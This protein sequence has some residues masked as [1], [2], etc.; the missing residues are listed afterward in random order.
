MER[1][2]QILYTETMKFRFRVFI[3][4]LFLTLFF[5]CSSNEN[6]KID[7]GSGWQ[8][9][10][11][12]PDRDDCNFQL[13][14]DASLNHLE[15]LLTESSKQKSFISKLFS[16]NSSQPKTIWLKKDFIIPVELQREDI[17]IYLGHIADS[18]KTYLNHY[19]IGNTLN[20][21]DTCF[22]YFNVPRFYEIPEELL[23]PGVNTIVIEITIGRHGFLKGNGFISFYKD[24]RIAFVRDKFFSELLYFAFAVILFFVS[25]IFISE[26]RKFYNK[27]ELILFCIISFLTSIDLSYF[28]I[29]EMPFI[30]LDKID[31]TIFAVIF[32]IL[33]PI[34]IAIIFVLFLRFLYQKEKEYFYKI[35]YC[36]IIVPFFI[37]LDVFLQFGM[38]FTFIP[39]LSYYSFPLCLILIFFVL[40]S[41]KL[42][43]LKPLKSTEDLKFSRIVPKIIDTENFQVAYFFK[44]AR[45]AKELMYD[46]FTEEN[47]LTGLTIFETAKND[48]SGTNLIM[49]AKQFVGKTFSDNKKLSLTKVMEKINQK[50]TEQNSSTNFLNGTLLRFSENRVE[51]V[52]SSHTVPFYRVSKTGVSV[53]VKLKDSESPVS[54]IGFS[55]LPGDAVILYSRTFENSM[56]PEQEPFSAQRIQQ[57]F[58]QSGSGTSL[59]RLEYILNMFHNYT[60][61]VLS[62]RDLAVLIVQK[63]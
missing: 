54:G 24:A 6:V 37:I 30:S 40:F 48:S 57:A 12:S 22:S 60:N 7:L 16:G 52:N 58:R 32:N 28:F 39:V 43:E 18:D 51:Y 29:N 50:I 17:S 61:G 9:S 46:I 3:S 14:P 23:V 8:Y 20:S 47:K 59:T 53:P 45:G 42:K 11:V 13:L 15:T 44:A 36:S 26:I 1:V 21:A 2:Y 56:N 35:F 38:K 55:M 31:Y 10:T 41:K 27:V 62:S 25:I 4:L 49:I 63:K 5:S 19:L 33:L 34:S